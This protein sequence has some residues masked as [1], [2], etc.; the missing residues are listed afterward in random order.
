MDVQQLTNPVVCTD[1]MWTICLKSERE[2]CLSTINTHEGSHHIHFQ[3][4]T[5]VRPVTHLRLWVNLNIKQDS[6]FTIS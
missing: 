4:F 5:P 6:W 2:G 1:R 3:K